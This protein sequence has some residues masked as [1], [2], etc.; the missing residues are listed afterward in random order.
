ME[1]FKW[2]KVVL[3]VEK[4]EIIK[5]IDAGTSYT[6]PVMHKVTTFLS[7]LIRSVYEHVHSTAWRRS[8]VVWNVFRLK[9]K[10]VRTR[11]QNMFERKAKRVW[12]RRQTR[13][14]ETPNVFELDAK[15][16]WTIVFESVT[17]H[18]RSKSETRSNETP[19]TFLQHPKLVQ[20]YPLTVLI[21]T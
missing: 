16:I 5:F 4:L 11:S 1:K 8:I 3:I 10:D 21:S 20:S 13:S 17:D 19:N 14:N 6:V 7:K 2:R 18:V 15:R 9:A 12:T